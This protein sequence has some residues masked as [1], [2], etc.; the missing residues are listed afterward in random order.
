M[1][2]FIEFIKAKTEVKTENNYLN[3]DTNVKI[4]QFQTLNKFDKTAETGKKK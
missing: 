1:L 3:K 4:K 2:G